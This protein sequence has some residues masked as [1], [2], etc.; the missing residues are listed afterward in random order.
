MAALRSNASAEGPSSEPTM[1]SRGLERSKSRTWIA[2]VPLLLAA[3]MACQP[4]VATTFS[5]RSGTVS[6]DDVEEPISERSKSFAPAL[7]TSNAILEKLREG[8]RQVIYRDLLSPEFKAI[9]TEE[10]W[11][12]FCSAMDRDCGKLVRFKPMQW[13]FQRGP[14]QGKTCVLSTKIVEFEKRTIEIVFTFVDDGAYAKPWSLSTRA[15]TKPAPQ[16]K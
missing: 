5:N 8:D 9:T 1:R 6:D 16:P 2:A 10:Q 7:E 14:L 15:R 12:A 4:S 13:N 11:T 3:L